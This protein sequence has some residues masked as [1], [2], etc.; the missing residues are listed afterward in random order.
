MSR[1]RERSKEAPEPVSRPGPRRRLHPL[2]YVG[3]GACI[4]LGG[5]IGLNVLVNWWHVWQ[6]DLHYGRPRTYQTDA[7]VGHHDEQTPSHFMVFNIHRRVEVIEIEGGDPSHT[8]LYVGPTILGENAELTP[9]TLVF[10]DVNG[11]GLLD[12]CLE[13]N[14]VMQAVLLNDKEGFR[15]PKADEHITL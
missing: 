1:R 10:K 13:I 5:W 14:G 11:D 3:G 9:V 4:L 7:R 2:T 8:K 6:D 12:M 15:A